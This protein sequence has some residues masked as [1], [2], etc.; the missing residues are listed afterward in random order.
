MDAS[1]VKL[2]PQDLKIIADLPLENCNQRADAFWK[3]PH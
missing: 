2:N 3:S 1:D